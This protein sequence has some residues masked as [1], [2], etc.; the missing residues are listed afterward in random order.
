MHKLRVVVVAAVSVLAVSAFH[1]ATAGASTADRMVAQINSARAAHG[2]GPLRQ[3]IGINRSSYSW[4]SF[5]MRKDWLGHASL[6][7]ARVRGEV[8]EMH[9][10]SASRVART[11]RNWMNSGGHRAILLSRSFRVVG[12]GKSTGRFGG[13][14]ATIWVARFR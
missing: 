2:L 9:S 12:V 5:L 10:G 3:S 7:A 4:A 11:V 6:R 14:S 8:I 1:S 13:R